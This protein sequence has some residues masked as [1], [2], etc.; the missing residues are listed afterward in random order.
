MRTLT[1]FTLI[2]A[3]AAVLTVAV[4]ACG[5]SSPTTTTSGRDP[6]PQAAGAAGFRYATCMR[7]HGVSGFPDPV[8]HTSSSGGQTTASVIIRLTPGLE[9]SPAFKSAQ[10]ACGRILPG[11]G[12]DGR[13]AAEQHARAQALLAF[14]RCLRADGVQG[15][16]DPDAQGELSLQMVTAAGV[17]IHTPAFRAAANGCVGVTHGQI[18][19]ADVERAINGPH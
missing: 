15:F 4:A 9:G 2:A 6:G 1:R 13:S 17:D 7:D 10:A 12:G 19:G 18:T 14:A 16:P 5:G 3:A 8:V 11:P